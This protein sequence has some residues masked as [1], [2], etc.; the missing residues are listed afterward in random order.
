MTL[1]RTRLLDT[2]H[3][4]IRRMLELAREVPDPLLLV[5]GDPDFGTSEH[6]IDG[7]AAAALGGATGYAPAIGIAPLRAAIAKKLTQVNRMEADADQICVV[8]GACG[9][10]YTTLLLLV[11]PGDDVLV[12][13]PGW[14]NYA[15]MVHVLGGRAVGYPVGPSTGWKLDPEAVEAAV[16][17]KTRAIILNSPGNPTGV[18]WTPE[19]L[20]AVVA[21]AARRG[22]PVV[23]DEA[24][25]ELVFNG[26]P[27]SVGSVAPSPELISV[28]TFSK[29]YAMTGW[30]IG[31]V[32]SDADFTRELSLHQE[33][34]TSGASMVSQHAALAALEGPQRAVSE[35]VS[36]YRQRR[37]QVIGLLCAADVGF[38]RPDGAFYLM[39][40]IRATGCGSWEFATELLRRRGVG[41]VP[42]LAFGS[43]GE[44]YVR[45]SLAV[46]PEVVREGVTRLLDLHQELASRNG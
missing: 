40:D 24:Y 4:G 35:M 43:E 14:S 2:P 12:P 11:G 13:N 15:A 45:V 32:H 36:A 37:D 42:G 9:G 22:I 8:T 16:S 41:V 30:R 7:A 21:L 19:S 1:L 17:A 31:Y 20:Q 3:S 39:V 5:S 6:I 38:V 44:G 26:E 25:D 34:V 46:A 10:L 23:S 28:F 18:V 27:F 33:P 29:T